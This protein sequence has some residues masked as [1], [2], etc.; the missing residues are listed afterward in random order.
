MPEP[1]KLIFD[2]FLQSSQSDV[3]YYYFTLIYTKISVS[4][5]VSGTLLNK[6]IVKINKKDLRSFKFT[7]QRI[8]EK[9]QDTGKTHN[10]ESNE[11]LTLMTLFSN[12][13]ECSNHTFTSC[14]FSSVKL[15]YSLLCSSLWS[16]RKMH[17]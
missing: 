2:S 4:P 17:T 11:S 1:Q 12:T 10:T 5:N 7:I 16:I 6:E 9:A 3:M 8:E 15:S 14:S 13:R